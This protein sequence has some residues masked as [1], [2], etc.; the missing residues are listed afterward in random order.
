MGKKILVFFVP[1]PFGPKQVVVFTTLLPIRI[2]LLIDPDTQGVCNT[3]RATIKWVFA[4]YCKNN[5][6]TPFAF[7]HRCV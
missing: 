3:Y 6:Q 2:H 1:L 4:C 5:A 7:L